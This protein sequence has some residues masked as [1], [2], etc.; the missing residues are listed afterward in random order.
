MIALRQLSAAERSAG[1]TLASMAV[2]LGLIGLFG[3]LISSV[4]IVSTRSTAESDT[5]NRVAERNRVA[6]LRVASDIRT[7]LS[8]TLAIANGGTALDFT[9]P[10]FFDGSVIQP[11]AS[12]RYELQLV[13]GETANSA[14]DNGNGLIDEGELVRRDITASEVVAICQGLDLNN[15]SFA[16]NGTSVTITLT[17][18]G[19]MQNDDYELTKTLTV[20]SRN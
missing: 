1:L 16:L 19:S 20:A 10:G 18:M 11:G 6:V 17:N 9:L 3:G 15:S 13:S 2:Y 14:D 12:I 7:S 4:V 8:D 5:M